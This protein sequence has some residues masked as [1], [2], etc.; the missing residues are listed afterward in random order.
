MEDENI[1]SDLCI[2]PEQCKQPEEI[3]IEPP[4]DPITIC[5]FNSCTEQNV[6][7]CRKCNRPFCIMH[8]NTFS[9]NF[10]QECFRDLAII[11][12]KFKRT[13]DHIRDNGQLQHVEKTRTRYY[14]DGPDWP[15]VTPWIH[16]L[17]DDELKSLWVFHHCIMKLIEVENETRRIEH[18]R[19][20]REQQPSSR[21]ITQ[22]SITSTG[23]RIKKT[24]VQD[25]PEEIRKKLRKQNIPDVIIEQM[26][27]AMNI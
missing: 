23:T 21:L 24:I 8:S 10:C 22:S 26:I 11:E 15:F 1:L 5:V 18:N 16:R 7:N 13:F 4:A 12:G 27:K 3:I 19:K 20:I 17:S 2:D 25:G 6:K 9:P 14:M